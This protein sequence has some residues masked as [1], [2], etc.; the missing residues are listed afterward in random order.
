[1]FLRLFLTDIT[2]GISIYVVSL[3]KVRNDNFYLTKVLLIRAPDTNYVSLSPYINTKIE[4]KVSYFKFKFY[5]GTSF[6]LL[7]SL[8]PLHTGTF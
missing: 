5:S 6:F 2:C 4:Q 1:M 3:R 7:H 8:R